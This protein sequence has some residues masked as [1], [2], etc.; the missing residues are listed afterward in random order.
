MW[1]IGIDFNGSKITEVSD[2]FPLHKMVFL[3]VLSFIILLKLNTLIYFPMTYAV[4]GNSFTERHQHSFVFTGTKQLQ[5]CH[6]L[7]RTFNRYQYQTIQKYIKFWQMSHGL[8]KLTTDRVWRNLIIC[9]CL[10]WMVGMQ[11]PILFQVYENTCLTGLSQ[12]LQLLR[13]FIGPTK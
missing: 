6:T 2:N 11:L 3:Q 13:I 1:D 12:G 9:A 7:F 5:K 10:S 4:L 8:S